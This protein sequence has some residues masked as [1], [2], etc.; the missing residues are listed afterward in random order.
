MKPIRY[1]NLTDEEPDAKMISRIEASDEIYE[2]LEK[3]E[4]SAEQSVELCK[5]IILS[6]FLQRRVDPMEVFSFFSSCAFIYIDALEKI[7][8]EE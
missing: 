3:Y 5:D 4:F 1:K 8:D 6:M 2:I 7:K